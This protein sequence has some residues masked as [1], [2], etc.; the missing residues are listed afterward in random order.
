MHGCTYINS[1]TKH[2]YI[3]DRISWGVFNLVIETDQFTN[4]HYL[5]T[6]RNSS[7]LKKGKQMV[8]HQAHLIFGLMFSMLFGLTPN[9]QSFHIS[10][11]ET[12]KQTENMPV[13]YQNYFF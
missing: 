11:N 6:I 8:A 7:L 1:V 2:I 9:P 4:C 10:R 13:K 12:N 3:D 5:V